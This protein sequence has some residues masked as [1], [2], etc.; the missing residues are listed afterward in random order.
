MQKALVRQPPKLPKRQQTG[1][2]N[3][4]NVNTPTAKTVTRKRPKSK[5]QHVN[6]SQ[7]GNMSTAK[8]VTRQQPKCQHTNSQKETRQQPKR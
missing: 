5:L 6:N 8:M 2:A 7:N 1:Q 3:S 4:K